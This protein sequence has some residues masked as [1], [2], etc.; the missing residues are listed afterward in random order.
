MTTD[1]QDRRDKQK[2]AVP[3]SRLS[4]FGKVARFA[5]GVAG[6]VL[7][8]G[9]RQ[10]ADGKAPKARDLLLTPANARRLANQ[11]ADMRGAAM[12][13]GQLLSMDSGDFL[14]KE[15]TDIL[16]KLRDDGHSMPDEQLE[17]QLVAAYGEDW[18]T[19]LYGFD[20]DPVA[21]ASIGQVHTAMAPDGKKIALKIQ[22]P[23]IANSI[24]SDVDNM[25]TI[26]KVSGLL[27]KNVD[28]KPFLEEAKAQLH[29]EA[30]Y[31]KEAEYLQAFREALADDPHFVVP[32]P[33]PELSCSHILA[34]EYVPSTP[35]EDMLD[36][37]QAQRDAIAHELIEL[38]FR[39]LFE[40][41]LVQTDPNFANYRYQADSQR[42]VLLDFGAC[43]RYP[44]SFSQTYMQLAKSL[45][46]GDDAATFAAAEQMGY[47][48]GDAGEDYLALVKQIFD[49]IAEPLRFEGEYD[50]AAS[51]LNTR[52]NELGMEM[53]NFRHAWRAPPADA[54]FFHRK[55]GGLFLLATRLRA[56]VNVNALLR[57]QLAARQ[58]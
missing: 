28:I 7:S 46:E 27:P 47:V 4:R 43:R 15:L 45:L 14:P 58:I 23:G 55:L 21:T 8:E 9:A 31:L 2:K 18:Q 29:D 3:T 53:Q 37:N 32:K 22:Y 56:K 11:L 57:T 17:Q 19:E 39:E 33:Y 36:A 38:V 6:S 24:D 48:V 54:V 44:E 16:A 5:G 26:L 20:F 12:K 35:I 13:M 1:G 34:M 50:F 52:L 42:I 51:N 25:A 49:L 41:R 10:L 40:L 30:D